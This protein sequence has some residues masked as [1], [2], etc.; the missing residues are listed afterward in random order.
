MHASQ[1]NTLQAHTRR[2]KP[3]KNKSLELAPVMAGDAVDTCGAFFRAVCPLFR[4]FRHQ[5]PTELGK[6]P[7]YETLQHQIDVA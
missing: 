4:I 2:N 1:Q 7:R 6:K 5:T 3:K